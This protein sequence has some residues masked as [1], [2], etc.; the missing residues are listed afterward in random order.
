M[1]GVRCG[2][3]QDHGDGAALVKIGWHADGEGGALLLANCPCMST[4]TIE[5]R[6]DASICAECRRLVPGADG[7]LKVVTEDQGVL[8]MG[9]AR[10]AGIPPFPRQP[11]R[12]IPLLAGARR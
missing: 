3:G 12:R 1:G 9:C 5:T 11:I 8:C 2:C 4:I 7:D 10:R 6:A